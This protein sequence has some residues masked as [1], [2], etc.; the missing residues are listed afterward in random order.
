MIRGFFIL[1]AFQLLGEV[2]AIPSQACSPASPWAQ[3]H[4]HPGSD[5]G[6]PSL[7]DRVMQ[8]GRSPWPGSQ[9]VLWARA[10]IAYRKW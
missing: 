1:L 2:A 9:T 10:K 3:R 4:R 5:P 7:T 6:A 8:S